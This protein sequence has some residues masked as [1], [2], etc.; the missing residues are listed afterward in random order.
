MFARLFRACRLAFFSAG[1]GLLLAACPGYGDSEAC[2]RDTQC[3]PGYVC[4]VEAGHC[5]QNPVVLCRDPRDCGETETCASDGTCRT[6]DCTWG[7]I[8]CVAGFVCTA[9]EG[10]WACRAEGA[11]SGEGGAG[12]SSASSE[13]GAGGS[14]ASSEAGAGG[15]SASSEGG[16]SAS[17]EGGASGA[18][19]LPAGAASDG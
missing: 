16:S 13:A 1:V 18:S 6:G 2:V 17:S 7:D 11:G 5:V 15:S 12:G 10:I 19:A 9:D 4:D 8:G 14:S 3:A